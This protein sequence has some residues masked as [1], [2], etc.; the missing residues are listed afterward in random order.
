MKSPMECESAEPRQ[1]I[2][3]V[4]F[5]F[6][7]LAIGKQVNESSPLEKHYDGNWFVGIRHILYCIVSK[8]DESRVLPQI[9]KLARM[10]WTLEIITG[11]YSST[12]TVL[13]GGAGVG[14]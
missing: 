5:S 14:A 13:Q 11:H 8:E 7:R 3:D 6:P 4:I 10:T 1:S 9:D 12:S 2:K